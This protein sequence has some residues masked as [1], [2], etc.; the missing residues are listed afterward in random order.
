LDQQQSST[1]NTDF[2][3]IKIIKE[4]DWLLTSLL[5]I[6]VFIGALVSW[7]YFSFYVR[8][9]PSFNSI[10]DIT[11]YLV[12]ICIW[13]SLVTLL[14]GLFSFTPF[15]LVHDLSSKETNTSRTIVF[16]FILVPLLTTIAYSIDALYQLI[17]KYPE[18]VFLSSVSF[19][20]ATYMFVLQ[21]NQNNHQI[22]KLYKRVFSILLFRFRAIFRFVL[23]YNQNNYQNK[24]IYK[25]RKYIWGYLYKIIFLLVNTEKLF[26]L[27]IYACIM[28]FAVIICMDINSWFL[29]FIA[30]LVLINIFII[31]DKE[32][33]VKKFFGIIVL[34]IIFFSTSMQ[35]AK[36]DNIIIIAPFK[37]LQLGNYNAELHFKKEFIMNEKPFALNDKNLTYGVF[38]VLSSIGD[39]YIIQEIR[40]EE[41]INSHLFYKLVVGGKPYYYCDNNNS[42][43]IK[44][45]DNSLTKTMNFK[46]IEEAKKLRE[47]N[48]QNV[49]S[50]YRI[51]KDNITF[52]KT[53]NSINW[54]ATSWLVER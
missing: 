11:A 48:K 34:M 30:F 3:A 14:N 15:F 51:D 33:A 1:V 9:L 47:Y 46:I 20:P 32:Y 4:W 35:F 7:S 10:G 21:Y 38:K 29:L 37:M 6:S 13:A 8:V 42:V 17:N 22:K 52:E 2:K 43:F 54:S 49:N 12:L 19:L 23:Q 26:F 28:T 36:K 5:K 31:T 25:S 24:K 50:S 41:K 16:F 44:N 27:C 18:R 40:V 39:E 53:G 45:K